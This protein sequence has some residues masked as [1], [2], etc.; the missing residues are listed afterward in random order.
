MEIVSASVLSKVLSLDLLSCPQIWNIE[1]DKQRESR[2]QAS[3][4]Q[5]EKEQQKATAK[6]KKQ[7]RLFGWKSNMKIL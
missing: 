4:A 6:D 1:K 2:R 5:R 3:Q 7:Q